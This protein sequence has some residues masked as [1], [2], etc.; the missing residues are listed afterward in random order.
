MRGMP[1]GPNASLGTFGWFALTWVL[2]MAAMML[3]V[4][5]PLI[6]ATYFGRRSGARPSTR[7]LAAGGSVA[8]YLAVWSLAGAAVYQLSGAKRHWLER[9]RAPLPASAARSP[10]GAVA[11]A[12]AGLGAGVRCLAC[13]WAL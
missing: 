6:D 3:P 13:S 5:A 2:M 8:G 11:G 1:A 9:C 12:G 7:T 4:I 10:G